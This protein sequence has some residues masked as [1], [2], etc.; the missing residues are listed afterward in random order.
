MNKLSL[1]AILIFLAGAIGAVFFK[2]AFLK[3]EGP[4]E[5]IASAGAGAVGG[6]VGAIIG[7][8]LFPKKGASDE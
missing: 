3:F 8:T 4:M 1:P 5:F 6:L 7:M 2:D